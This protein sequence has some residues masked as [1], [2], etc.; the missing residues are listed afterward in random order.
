MIPVLHQSA[1]QTEKKALQ[2]LIADDHTIVRIGLRIIIRNINSEVTIEE[3]T[4]GESVIRKLKSGR[5]DLLILDINMPRTESFSLVGY[6][7]KEF[8]T[9][10]ILIFT[11]NQESLFAKRFLKLG[12]HG[13]MIKQSKGS[14]IN[15]AIQKILAGQTYISDPLLEA[16]SNDLINNKKNNPFEELSDREFELVLQILRGY[17][18]SEIAETLHLNKSSVRT[19]KARIMDKLKLS[20]TMELLNLAKQYKVL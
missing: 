7:I 16:I 8:R 9:L 19:H 15:I 20:N 3:A 14:E 6:L 11:I 1:S 2:I 13:Y 12:V 4:D 17:S 5:F 10:K 18:V